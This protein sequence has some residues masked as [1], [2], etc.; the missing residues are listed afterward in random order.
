MVC[1]LTNASDYCTITH[2]HDSLWKEVPLSEPILN[3][4]MGLILFSKRHNSL[5][6]ILQMALLI[7]LYWLL[8]FNYFQSVTPSLNDEKMAFHGEL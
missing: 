6:E 2:A 8:L 5:F 7:W 3:H 4:T 1:R